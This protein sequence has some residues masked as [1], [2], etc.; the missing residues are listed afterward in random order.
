MSPKPTGYVQ[1]NELVLLRTF[2]APIADVWTSVTD[3]ESTAR[4]IGRWEGNAA[5]GANVRLQLLFEQG[6]PWSNVTIVTCEPPHRLVVTTQD[7]AGQW[8][9]ELTLTQTGATTELR[10]VQL[11]DDPKI[12]GEVGPGWEYYLD[13]LD[14]A[15]EG[16]PM[17][18]FD[19]Y[20]PAQKAHYAATDSTP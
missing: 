18:S 2:R 5:V 7:E 6:Q 8:R 19:D 4:W 12:A 20:Y 10:F 11:L 3:P 13:R 15:R 9:L 1:G 16:H 14:A 17:P